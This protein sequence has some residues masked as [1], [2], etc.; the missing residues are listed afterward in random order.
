MENR[1]WIKSQ[2]KKGKTINALW[3]QSGSPTIVEA[4]VYA[5][6][7][8]ILIDN[9]HG[10]TDLET[11]IHM[12]RAVEGAG[13]HVIVRVPWNDQVYL[14]RILDIGV[15]S[16]MIPMINDKR[17]AEDGVAACRYPPHGNRGYAAP[18]IRASQYG[19]DQDYARN[20]LNELLLI[21]QV[22]HIDAVENI[23]DIGATDGIDALF[24]GPM[25]LAGSMNHFEDLAAPEVQQTVKDIEKKIRSTGKIMGCFPLPKTSLADLERHGHQLIAAQ[26]DV[27]LFVRAAAQAAAEW[28]KKPT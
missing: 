19:A 22:E 16:L 2:L 25:D 4:A 24:I 27:I 12:I 8:V 21:A 13:G 20:A 1:N 26:S 14:K 6:W 15:Q 3:S 10:F 9:E 28:G 7:S 17:S 11:T 5:G 23:V 18:L